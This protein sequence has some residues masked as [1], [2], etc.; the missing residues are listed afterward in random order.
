M[1]YKNKILSTTGCL[2]LIESV[3]SNRKKRYLIKV[4][5]NRHRLLSYTHMTKLIEILDPV[6]N[7]QVKNYHWKFSSKTEATNL[8][9]IAVLSGLSHMR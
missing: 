4:L 9:T 5:D 1:L 7:R 6:G 8:L 3:N 2:Q